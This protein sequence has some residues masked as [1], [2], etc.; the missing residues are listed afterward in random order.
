MVLELLNDHAAA[1]L[2][3]LKIF[4][5]GKEITAVCRHMSYIT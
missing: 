1:L 3:F 5:S 2:H 4:L